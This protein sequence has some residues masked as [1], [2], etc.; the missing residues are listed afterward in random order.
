M[1][2]RLFSLYWN[3]QITRGIDILKTPQISSWNRECFVPGLFFMICLKHLQGFLR[4]KHSKL[5]KSI[6][7]DYTQSGKQGH[8]CFLQKFLR[9]I[10][11]RWEIMSRMFFTYLTL[12]KKTFKIIMLMIFSNLFSCSLKWK[13]F[14]RKLLKKSPKKKKF[15]FKKI[16]LKKTDWEKVKLISNGV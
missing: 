15:L 6:F 4:N 7:L 11:A 1:R 16:T 13:H 3:V 10:I 9:K 14:I 12:L 2:K 5:P 8:L